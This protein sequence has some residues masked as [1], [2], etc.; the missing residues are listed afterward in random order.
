MTAVSRSARGAAFSL[1]LIALVCVA[2]PAHAGL[3]DAFSVVDKYETQIVERVTQVVKG[4]EMKRVIATLFTVMAASLF[5]MKCAGWALRG[6]QLDD[7]V[8]TMMQ[9]LLTGAMIS[10]FPVVVPAIFDAS[11]YVGHIMLSGITGLSYDP[12]HASTLPRALV[13]MMVDYG[14]SLRPDCPDSVLDWLNPMKLLACVKGSIVMVVATVAMSVVMLVL[15]MVVMAV[16]VWGFWIYA[17]ALAIGPLMLPFSLYPRLAFLFEGW[18]RFF[19]GVVVYVIVARVNLS[20]V[21]VAIMAYQKSSITALVSGG[22][23]LPVAA[24]I[25]DFA[26]VL[27][28]MLFCAVGI[29][30]LLATGRFSSAIVAGAAAGGL[31]L[32][33]VVSKTKQVV[34]KGV[35]ERQQRRQQA[36]HRDRMN[37]AYTDRLV[38]TS[39]IVEDYAENTLQRLPSKV[40]WAEVSRRK[41]E[42]AARSS[43]GGQGSRRG[44]RPPNRGTNGRNNGP[45]SGPQRRSGRSRAGGST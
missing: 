8:Y 42:R 21:A 24:P 18:L 11:L 13:Q 27:G 37:A 10:S 5:L 3:G 36:S 19:F 32:G 9:I 43:N 29:F 6:F 1:V 12:Q 14:K 17:I 45:N 38:R 34:Q 15:C 4:P 22:F 26:S 35:K 44:G 25:K 41:A 2:L 20:L 23:L 39:D 7:M 28:M 31:N 33:S 16:D 40:I 30:T